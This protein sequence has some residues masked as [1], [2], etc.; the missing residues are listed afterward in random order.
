MWLKRLSVLLLEAI[1]HTD[2]AYIFDNSGL[3]QIWLA[4]VNVGNTLTIK[5]DRMPMWFKTAV[6]NKMQPGPTT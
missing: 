4:G 3:S 1:R 2:R 5:T 6:W